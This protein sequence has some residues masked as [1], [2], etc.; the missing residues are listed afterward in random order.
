M[1]HTLA[2][3]LLMVLL[4]PTLALGKTVKWEDL[5]EREVVYYKKFTDGP[6]TGAETGKRQG[7]FK[8]GKR[9]GPWVVYGKNGQLRSQVSYKNGEL[10]GPWVGYHENG[11]LFSK[12]TFKDGVRVK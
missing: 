3:I 12:G 4:F 6:F 2:P 5:V 8:N 9:E 1:N 10:D 7:T 11:Y